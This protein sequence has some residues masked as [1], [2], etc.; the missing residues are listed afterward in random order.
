MRGMKRE[1]GAKKKKRLVIVIIIA[2]I[3]AAVLYFIARTVLPHWEG[4]VFF[5][6]FIAISGVGVY[7]VAKQP[8]ER[9]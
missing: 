3:V 1:I 8:E 4:L 2:L 9:Y 5:S 7:M 6:V